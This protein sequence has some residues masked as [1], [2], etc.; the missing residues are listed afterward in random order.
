[1]GLI[2]SYEGVMIQNVVVV[3]KLSEGGQL[4]KSK[5]VYI[6]F[7][8]MTVDGSPHDVT[9]TSKLRETSFAR[10]CP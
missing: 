2:Y 8:P 6:A 4:K 1:M 10:G 5:V 9:P 7:P 3:M